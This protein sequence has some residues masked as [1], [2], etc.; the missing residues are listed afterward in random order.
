MGG[1]GNTKKERNGLKIGPG[2][3]PPREWQESASS[4]SDA[5]H[6]HTH[7]HTPPASRRRSVHASSLCRLPDRG[8]EAVLLTTRRTTIGGRERTIPQQLIGREVG[9]SGPSGSAPNV[10]DRRQVQNA[11]FFF[12]A[13]YTSSASDDF[14]SSSVMF[15]NV[16]EASAASSESAMKILVKVLGDFYEPLREQQVC[17]GLIALVVLIQ[18]SQ[19]IGRKL[20]TLVR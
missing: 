6:A 19:K 5:L 14:I 10:P 4:G 7:T 13:K 12:I 17:I 3:L 15:G 1:E 18:W 9:H 8:V 20:L 11:W 16:P 2:S